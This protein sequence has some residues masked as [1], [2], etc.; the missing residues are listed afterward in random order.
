MAVSQLPQAPYRQDRRIYPTPIIGDVLFSEVRDC[1]RI[2]IP[3]YGTP[4]PNPKKWPD[5]KLVFVKPVDIERDGIFEFFYAAERENQDLYN[6]SSGY[7]NVV[8]NAGGREFRVVQ[9]TYVTLRE[10]FKPM[11]IEFGTPM[12]DV[13]EGKFSDVEYVF[14]DRQQQ[15]IQEQELNA[16]F[17]AEVHTYIEKAFLE[18]KLSYGTQ[19]SEV[20]PEKFRALI[21]QTSTEQIVEGLAEQ[22]TLTGSQLSVTEDQINPDIK[23]VRTVS[24]ADQQTGYSLS[25]KQV[26]NVLQ[27][28]DVVETIV[29]DGTTIETTAL[30]VDGSIE[31][32]GNGQSIQRVITA[33]EL[34]AAESY[35][36]QRPD[37]VPEKFRVLTPTENIEE[38]VEGTAAMPTLA[39]G[40]LQVSEQQLNVHVKRK[41]RTKRNL[42]TLPKSI[43][44][45]VTTGEK[46][47]AT[48]TDTLQNGDTTETPTATKDIQSD[49]LGDGTYVVRK[50]EVPELFSAKGFT[51]QKS[52][53]IPEK[54]RAQVPTNT[55]QQNKI[56]QATQ[57]SLSAGEL[58][59][60]QQQLNEFVYREQITKRDVVGDVT[61]PEVKR[62]YVE[63]T[64]ASVE[65]KLTSDPTIESGFLVSESAANPI[66]DG[67]FIVQTV[68]V[69]SWPEL[70]SSEWDP[71]LNTQVVRTEQF[72]TP[73]STFNEDNTAYRAINEDR[74]LKV[75]ENVPLEALNNY[76]MSF[77]IQA[78]LQL[79]NV[80]KRL[81]VVWAESVSTGE[82]TSDWNG[83]VPQPDEVNLNASESGSATTS[84]S[85]KPELIVDIEQPWGSD[86]S[87]TAYYFFMK[88]ENNSVTETAFLD[89]LTAINGGNVVSR[90]PSFRPVSHTIVLQ[91][92]AGTVKS[93][94][95]VS[96]ASA[97]TS[98]EE[99]TGQDGTSN[100]GGVDS[101]PYA[102][103]SGVK[104]W[105]RNIGK[106]KDYD[107]DVVLNA[108]TIPP[109]I[110]GLI[111]IKNADTIY[112]N[113]T[114]KAN[115]KWDYSTEY[116][117]VAG[118]T[119]L[120]D[121][122]PPEV[123]TT[124]ITWWGSMLENGFI[125]P[126]LYFPKVD[127]ESSI[128]TQIVGD[129]NPK[130][131]EP[132]ALE[133][134]PTSGL[135]VI[136]STIE[137]YKWGWVKC[138]AWVLDA[139]VLA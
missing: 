52:D 67:K 7:R 20:V 113:I 10:K 78:D 34:F 8:G 130:Q 129:I 125:H 29:P 44:Q 59:R 3:E 88:S 16:L 65:E 72:V 9:R 74:T 22:P 82:F 118:G 131:L 133:K 4:H 105:E 122:Y 100:F 26:T 127:E 58:E 70:K 61:L 5:H 62:A 90:W 30:T 120:D 114:A 104:S 97:S 128:N 50:V 56:G 2:E 138:G 33:P 107:L 110:H 31:S 40:D 94:L 124:Y 98:Y 54:F 49:A 76:V 28:A 27:V 15:Q 1:T 126:S 55:E 37:P 14:F 87:A 135:Y 91:G 17:V 48:I 137:P 112:R 36:A 102:Y 23:V 21:P 47:V 79:P 66:G 117:Q 132:T 73:P 106:G 108:V 119:Y 11:D 111:D 71:V 84:V 24:R 60:S 18:Y 63:G 136:K 99:A 43:T 68:K 93:T 95:N 85:L 38:T 81:E 42:T 139:S 109:T 41:S 64:I 45:K 19:K 92:V 12:M 96:A 35:S 46:Q 83:F 115:V 89:R 101:D 53:T 39:A 6:F 32:L 80:L 121:G 116:T 86:I 75:I 57:P 51:A 25:G 69:N 77:P 103:P 134:I 13:P 123:K